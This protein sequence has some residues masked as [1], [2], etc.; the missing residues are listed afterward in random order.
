VDW[1]SVY[2]GGNWHI[3]GHKDFDPKAPLVNKKVRQALNIAIDREEM[4]RTVFAGRAELAYLSLWIPAS[5]GWNHGRA[6]S[7]R[8][9]AYTPRR[10][11]TC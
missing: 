7:T 1:V 10:R 8:C 5:E 9:Y 11:R 4:L 3:T 2:L 6:G